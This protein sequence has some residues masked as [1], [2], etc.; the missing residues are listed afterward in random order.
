MAPH[1]WI[2]NAT[3]SRGK[4]YTQFF[5]YMPQ[6]EPFYTKFEQ[7]FDPEQI[8]DDMKETGYVIPIVAVIAYLLFCYFG[9]KIMKDRKPFNLLGP[10]ACWNLL[11]AV[12]SAWGA[13]RMVPHSLFLLNTRPFV[14][15]ICEPAERTYAMGATGL[16]V[17]L[18][19]LS[20]LPELI[21]TVFIVLR[22]KPLIFL[23]WYHHVTVLV[24]AWN[25]YITEASNGH[26]FSSMNYTVHAVMYFYYFLQARKAIPKW[27]PSW[28][29]TIM[30]ISQMI[31]G[32]Y[33][34]IM[35]MYYYKYGGGKYAP[36]ECSNN[37][38]NLIAA[39]IIYSSYL[40]LFVEFAVRRFVFGIDDMPKK[41]KKTA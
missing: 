32:T 8:Y 35:S 17:M 2:N 3:H 1:P 37:M 13:I 22:K 23:H 29:I 9:T 7:N 11:L 25:C 31:M 16:A 10:L 15:T 18:F 33:L 5:H 39:G 28:I 41:T 12:F 6:A 40:Y 34:V 36:G 19:C 4:P 20:K 24:F 14:E 30:Q 27:F 26:Y 21:D 38:S